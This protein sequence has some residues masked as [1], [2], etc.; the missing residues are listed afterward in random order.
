MINLRHIVVATDLSAC[1]QPAIRYACDLAS[2]FGSHLHL[3]TVVP[4]PFA[5]FAEQ[6]RKEFGR[7]MDALEQEHRQQAT[8]ALDQTDVAP[9]TDHDAVTRII[10]AGIPRSEIPEYADEVDCDLLV[11]GTHGHSGLKHVLQ[12]SVA[13]AVTQQARCPVLCVRSFGQRTESNLQDA[14]RHER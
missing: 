5:E 4:F 9:L 6:C 13:E 1:S 11:V 14:E 2:S 10:R 12:G 8:S 7:S 3:L